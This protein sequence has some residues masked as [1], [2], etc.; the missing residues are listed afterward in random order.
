MEVVQ[1][2]IKV[3]IV[4]PRSFRTEGLDIFQGNEIADYDQLRER[5]ATE[6]KSTEGQIGDPIK[7]MEIL[8]DVVRGEGVAEGKTWPL[9]LPLGSDAEQAIRDKTATMRKVLDEWK[10]VIR[11]TD[12]K[13]GE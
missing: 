12:F 4:L 10:D 5:V 3:L 9:Y 6:W 7:A 8:V 1:F 11:S 2:S 13:E